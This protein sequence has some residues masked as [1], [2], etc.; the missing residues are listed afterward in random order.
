MNA[1]AKKKLNLLAHIARI[2]GDFHRL[3]REMMTALATSLGV[4][5]V[6]AQSLIDHTGEVPDLSGYQDTKEVLYLSLMMVQADR[7]I[8]DEEL[9]FC[10]HLATKLGFP[11]YTVDR[12]AHIPLPPMPEFMR[13]LDEWMVAC[14]TK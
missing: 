12:F 4:D 2:D 3:E 5:N 9:N 10:R 6:A 8:T 14:A 1:L 11:K 7:M 13:Q